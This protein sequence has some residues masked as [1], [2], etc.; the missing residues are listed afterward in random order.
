M[1]KKIIYGLSFIVLFVALFSGLALSDDLNLLF[2]QVKE[3]KLERYGYVLGAKLNQKQIKTATAN[4]I[5]AA[6]KDTFKFKDNNLFVVAQKKSNRVL[7]MYEQFEDAN[8]QKIQDLIGDLYM[9]FDEPTILAHDKIVYW[10]YGEKGKI[11]SREFDT[12][13]EDKKK[14][15]IIATVKFISDINIM[16]K[17][18]D[19]GQVYY[20]ISSDPVLKYFKD[21]KS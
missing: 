15:G 9:N 11:S 16:D 7:V 21:L 19:K 4:P 3:L 1:Q 8:R 6:S 20:I 14:I 12:A 13:K 2:K 5:D 18:P 17:E 10:A